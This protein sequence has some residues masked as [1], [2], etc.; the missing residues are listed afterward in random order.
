MMPANGGSG[1]LTFQLNQPRT[2]V[3]FTAQFNGDYLAG[4]P[5]RYSGGYLRPHLIVCGAARSASAV[6]ISSGQT[7]TDTVTPGS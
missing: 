6:K 4:P 7:L 5:H 2:V 1:L 3:C